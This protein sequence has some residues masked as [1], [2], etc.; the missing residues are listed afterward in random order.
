MQNPFPALACPEVS[1]PVPFGSQLTVA[2][3]GH[4]PP[5]S[6][7]LPTLGGNSFSL[8]EAVSAAPSAFRLAGIL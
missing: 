6:A 1:G 2:L 3:Q 4:R 8:V 5:A 7:Q